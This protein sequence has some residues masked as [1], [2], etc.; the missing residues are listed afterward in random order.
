[1]AGNFNRVFLMGNL[2]RDIE[3]RHTSNNTAVARIG[4]AVNRRYSVGEGSN[5]ENREETTFVDCEAWGRTAEVMAQYL[6]KGRPVFIEGRLKTDQW[7]DK[8]TG[9]NRS[10]LVV[11]IENFQFVDSRNDGGGGEGGGGRRPQAAGNSGG[12]RTGGEPEDDIPF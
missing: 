8:E 4:L 1:M 7:Q 2:T 6:S 10:R 3:L 9:A 11:V 5:R 12:G